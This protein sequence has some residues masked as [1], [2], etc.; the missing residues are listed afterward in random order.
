MTTALIVIALLII[1]ALASYAIYLLIHVRRQKKAKLLKQQQ[2]ATTA[3]LKSEELLDSIRFIAAAMLEERCELSEGVMRIV[4]LFGLL[5]MSELV[6][7]K[8]PST[9]KHFEVIASHP[10]KDERK[11]LTKQQRMKLDLAR[12]KSE[13]ILETS[14]LEEAK[15][16]REF[17]ANTLH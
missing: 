2:I 15:L 1:V 14:I 8:Y 11:A 3:K 16:L 17:D 9:F 10:I 5:G 13:G 4:K 7:D 12:I 6:I